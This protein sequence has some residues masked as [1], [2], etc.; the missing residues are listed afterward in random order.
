[1]PLLVTAADRSGCRAQTLFDVP[2]PSRTDA[3]VTSVSWDRLTPRVPESLDVDLRR[4]ERLDA[5]L[6]IVISDKRTLSIPIGEGGADPGRMVLP[7]GVT[8]RTVSPCSL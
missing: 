7:A 8:A 5:T 1:M 2:I 3:Y 6:K 4:G